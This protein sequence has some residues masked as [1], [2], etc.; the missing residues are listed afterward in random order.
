MRS[1]LAAPTAPCHTP[2]RT[3]EPGEESWPT[4]PCRA[5]VARGGERRCVRPCEAVPPGWPLRPPSSSRRCCPPPAPAAAADP[6]VLTVGTTQDLDASNPFNTALVVGYEAFELTYNLLVDFER[7]R[8]AGPGFAD[9]WERSSDGRVTFHI[10]D[11][12]KW[13]DGDAGDLEGRLLLVGPRD[14]RDQGRHEHR[15]RLPRPERQGR[16]RDEGRVPRR[17]HVHR[18]H[19]RPVGPDLPGLRPDPAR[20]RLE[21]V[22]LQD[23][24]RPEV[25]SAARR[26][27]RLHPR[28][29]EDGPVRALRPQPELLGQARASRTRSSSGSSR[30]R[31]T[32][33]SRP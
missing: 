25:R 7:E 16:R 8:Q 31:P 17:E 21:Q 10:R 13:S 22:R 32:S 12:M 9:T 28:R 29:V 23:D 14:R 6:V 4:D 19:D 20:A 2:R 26:H 18:L 24:R 30:T 15:L 33:W 1:S 27:R 11:G 5:R 3:I